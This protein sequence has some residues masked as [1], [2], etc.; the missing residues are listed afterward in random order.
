[1]KSKKQRLTKKEIQQLKSW[2]VELSDMETWIAQTKRDVKRMLR[3][4]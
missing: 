2:L 1:M 3:T 4:A